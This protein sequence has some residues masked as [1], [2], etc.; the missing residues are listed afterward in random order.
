[1][2]LHR[3]Q[4]YGLRIV[5][6]FEL[7]TDPVAPSKVDDEAD[8][9][10]A[11]TA[12][13]GDP[14]PSLTVVYC[15]ADTGREGE[16]QY[17]I[18]GDEATGATRWQWCDGVT[19]HVEGP[20]IDVYCPPQEALSGV[21]HSVV[22]PVLANLLR[23]RGHALLHGSALSYGDDAFAILGPS[24][25]GKSTLATALSRR[26]LRPLTD[27]VVALTAANGLWRA[28]AG[29]S[30]IRLWPDSAETLLGDASVL[31][32]M[33]ERTAYWT[34]FDKRYL[35]LRTERDAIAADPGPLRHIFVL[36]GREA[37]GPVFERLTGPAAVA[38]LDRN[39]YQLMLRGAE[40][41]RRDLAAFAALARQA[42]VWRVVP[43]DDLAAIDTLAAAIEER[44][45][46]Q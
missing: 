21:A 10:I 35:Q 13:A 33:L 44:L 38:A 12:S 2:A 42:A 22:G 6:D 39:A 17:L 19:I 29:Y 8:Y 4:L 23:R 3:Y 5:S 18:F 9:R 30:G 26:G 31:P 40:H 43:S 14:R 36:Q 45:R 20:R 1:M 37:R 34:G 28:L 7:P 25:A 24:G 16:P 41:H 11:A 15:S 46:E 27:D 32:L